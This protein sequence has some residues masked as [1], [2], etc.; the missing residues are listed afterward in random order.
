[1]AKEAV[2]QEIGLDPKLYTPAFSLEEKEEGGKAEEEQ[3]E[4]MNML[5][6]YFQ[7]KNQN[8]VTTSHSKIVKQQ[9]RNTN[10]KN[11]L[12]RFYQVLDASS[13]TLTPSNKEATP[14]R[15]LLLLVVAYHSRC[16]LF[17]LL[18]Q[19]KS[20]NNHPHHLLPEYN[21]RTIQ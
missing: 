16:Y 5:R 9:A 11:A 6:H 7:K 20:S 19:Y 1:M 14:P 21:Y 8:Q 2:I 13:T 15:L 17:N 10:L 4:E 18:N 12:V 3:E